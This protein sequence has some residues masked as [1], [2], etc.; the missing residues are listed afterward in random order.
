MQNNK[1]IRLSGVQ[2]FTQLD[3]P[4]RLACIAFFPGCNFR[5]GFCHNPEFVLTE[6][7]VKT[8]D[9]WIE[10]EVF[11]SFLDQRRGL[12]DGVVISGGEPTLHAGL[13]DFIQDIRDRGFQVKLDT[14][15]SLPEVL[16]P[17]LRD[18][19]LDY[20]AM[21]V[22]TSLERYP[23]LVSACV[24]TEAIK[25]SIALIKTYAP[26]YEFRTTIIPKI[27][28]KKEIAGIL[29]LVRGSRRYVLQAY[30]P[31]IT[32]DP[33]FGEYAAPDPSHLEMLAK[34]FRPHVGELI[35]R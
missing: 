29:E 34:Q 32:L 20:V 30:R 33:L 11:L 1:Q 22:K 4:G 21:D 10:G 25:E 27:H 28:G 19:L 5:C 8:A 9:S 14:N 13:P 2:P 7:L 31:A 16:G 17:L 26:E 15:G 24:R 6:R 18:G 35:V 3:F 12:L 23:E